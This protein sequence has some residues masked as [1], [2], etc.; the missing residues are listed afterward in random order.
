MTVNLNNFKNYL[1]IK[2]QYNIFK[3]NYI[4]YTLYI[5]NICK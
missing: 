2:M 5:M 4:N 3:Y 1:I